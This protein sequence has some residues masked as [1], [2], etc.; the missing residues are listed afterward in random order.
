MLC[1]A[2]RVLRN[3]S[4][5]RWTLKAG[6]S[7]PWI[8]RRTD[9]GLTVTALALDN[10]DVDSPGMRLHADSVLVREPGLLETMNIPGLSGPR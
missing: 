5:R 6:R 8:A 3:D 1:A 7:S 9:E 4:T 10:P 2:F